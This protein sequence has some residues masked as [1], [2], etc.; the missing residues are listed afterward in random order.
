MNILDKC[1][2]PLLTEKFKACETNW[3]KVLH[4]YTANYITKPSMCTMPQNHKEVKY[5]A[6][7]PQH[8]NST[9]IK[10]IH[11]NVINNSQYINQK[12][13]RLNKMTIYMLFFTTL[14]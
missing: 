5:I 2:Q 8:S 14:C 4:L 13:R 7:R 11:L 1:F 3:H 12:D 10:F 9:A 6:T